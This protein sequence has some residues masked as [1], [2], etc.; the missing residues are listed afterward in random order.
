MSARLPVID[1]FRIRKVPIF[2]VL[3]ISSLIIPI[4]ANVQMYS[5]RGR[6]E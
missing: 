4:L 6:H 3:N 5:A 2:E 1:R